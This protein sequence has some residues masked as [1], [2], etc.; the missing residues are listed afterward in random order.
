MA[1]T[2]TD[3]KQSLVFTDL[4]EE[5]PIVR[6]ATT[7]RVVVNNQILRFVLFSFDEGQLLTE[8]A[9]PR[10]VVVQLLGGRME[11]TVSGETSVLTGGDIVYLAPGARHALTA[12]EP[13]H[14][15][16]TLVN[17]PNELE[18]GDE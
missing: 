3:Y 4:V 8:H 11:F 6:E 12:L 10:A 5:L 13:C 2:T 17:V 9:S 16:L 18:E 1:K 7:S 14:M 15:A